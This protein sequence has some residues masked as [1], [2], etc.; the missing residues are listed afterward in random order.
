M[1]EE[2]DSIICEPYRIIIPDVPALET[3]SS[4]AGRL[5]GRHMGTVVSSGQSSTQVSCQPR[6]YSI[7]LQDDLD[8]SFCSGEEHEKLRRG[9]SLWLFDSGTSNA[10]M[11]ST[12]C[13]FESTDD[14]STLWVLENMIWEAHSFSLDKEA[15]WD[16]HSEVVVDKPSEFEMMNTTN[17][18]AKVGWALVND[19]VGIN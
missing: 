14:L 18:L 8:H 1:S 7:M 12:I 13:H 16:S 19:D 4:D 5:H 10:M 6:W 9:G 17:S 15:C 11:V 3:A 2:D